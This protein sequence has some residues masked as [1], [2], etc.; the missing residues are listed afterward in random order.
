MGK[1]NFFLLFLGFIFCIVISCGFRGDK[2]S[3]FYI[4]ENLRLFRLSL[5]F[6]VISDGVIVV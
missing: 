1:R 4:D 6:G 5:L 2:E 3:Y